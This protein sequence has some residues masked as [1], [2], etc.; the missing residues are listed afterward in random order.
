VEHEEAG[1]EVSERPDGTWRGTI[2]CGCGWGRAVLDRPDEAATDR[3]LHAAWIV[4]T[5]RG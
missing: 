2:A 3:A 1:H 5:G 4:H